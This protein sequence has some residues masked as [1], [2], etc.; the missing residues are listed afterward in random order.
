MPGAPQAALLMMGSDPYFNT[1]VNLSHF[2]GT[3]GQTG[4]LT[5]S[6]PRGNTIATSGGQLSTTLV[7]FGTTSLLRTSGT[8][9][10]SAAGSSSHADYQFGTN[11]FTI[12]FWFQ[13]PTLAQVNIF[14]MRNAG[15]GV[16]PVIYLELDGRIKY[17]STSDRITGVAGTIVAG[18]L[19]SI[20]YSRV[21]GTGRLFVGGNQVGSNFSD[22][23]NY[24]ATAKII[25]GSAN[26]NPIS[27]VWDELRISNGLY[28][29]GAGRY[30]ANY[31]V[32][33]QAFPNQ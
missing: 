5:N 10:T 25:M 28:G 33:T 3:N 23:T 1:V 8:P 29:G 20:A 4:T 27:G 11:D 15:S 21:G 13:I 16:N 19:Q 6:C 32:A 24:N 7:K 30:A 12:E 18:T 31:T 2:D 14:D 9:G 26:A 22:S 17:F